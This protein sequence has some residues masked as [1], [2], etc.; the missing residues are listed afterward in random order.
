MGNAKCHSGAVRT[1]YVYAYAGLYRYEVSMCDGTDFGEDTVQSWRGDVL[2]RTGVNL[3]HEFSPDFIGCFSRYAGNQ[4]SI[5]DVLF[6]SRTWYVE[7]GDGYVAFCWTSM[8]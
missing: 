7:F 3:S 8:S 2:R 6:V 4:D 1:R 5:C